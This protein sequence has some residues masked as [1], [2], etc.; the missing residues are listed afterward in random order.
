MY[1]LEKNEDYIKIKISASYELMEKICKEVEK[2][3]NEKK[4][5][6]K[7]F[8]LLLCTREALTNAIK[9]GSNYDISKSIYFEI[10]YI[11]NSMHVIVQDEGDGF[12][13]KSEK[14]NS[15]EILAINGRGRNIMKIYSN[16]VEYNDK[17]NIIKFIIINK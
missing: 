11:E 13:W 5:T 8:A 6:N 15:L 7:K 14:K 3:S 9:Y 17:G 4:F 10:K 16:S 1:K 2:F 12:D